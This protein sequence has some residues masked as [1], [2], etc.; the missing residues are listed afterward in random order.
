MQVVFIKYCSSSLPLVTPPPQ[1]TADLLTQTPPVSLH[2]RSLSSS[3]ETLY[4]NAS[5]ALLPV[6][7]PNNQLF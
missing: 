4:S 2:T 3:V 5:L 7:P 6:L 1:P